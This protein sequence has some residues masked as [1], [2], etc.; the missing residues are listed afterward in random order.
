MPPLCL[1]QSCVGPFGG[2]GRGIQWVIGRSS[3]G[4]GSPSTSLPIHP[5]LCHSTVNVPIP[6]YARI[7]VPS[8]GGGLSGSSMRCHDGVVMVSAR[9]F[10]CAAAS[11]CASALLSYLNSDVGPSV[12]QLLQAYLPKYSTGDAIQYDSSRMSVPPQSGHGFSSGASDIYSPSSAARAHIAS[13][14]CLMPT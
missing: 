9:V 7:L 3:L 11:L 13:S 14:T 12:S 6:S 1:C 5:Q 10:H 4:N 8:I 2:V